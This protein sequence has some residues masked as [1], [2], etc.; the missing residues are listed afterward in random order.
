MKK[1]KEYMD[2]VK[3]PDTLHRRLR[4]LKAPKKKPASWTRYGSMAAALALVCGLGGFLAWTGDVNS[5]TSPIPSYP[6]GHQ[7]SA[8]EIT[9]ASQ[10]DIAIV[11]PG[12]VTEPGEKTLGGYD[13]TGGGVTAHYI[14][15]YIEYGD[16]YGAAETVM[17]W[18]IPAGAVKRE[19]TRDEIAALMGGEDAVDTHL[20]WGGYELTGW[21]AWY[22]DGSFWGAYLYGCRGP[23]D[24]FEFAVT[25]GQLPPTCVAYAN[26]V[27]QE[28]RGL[29]V[30]A[31]GY[32]GK[33]GCGRRISFMKDDYG[34]RFDLTATDTEQA[35]LLVSRLVR[36]VADKGLELSAVGAAQADGSYTCS[37]CGRTVQEGAEHVHSNTFIGVGEPCYEDGGASTEPYDPAAS[38]E[39]CGLPLADDPIWRETRAPSPPAQCQSEP[40]T[41][42]VLCSEGSADGRSSNYEWTYTDTARGEGGSVIACGLHP[43]DYRDAPSLTTA[44]ETVRLNF[45]D[46]P[47]RVSVVCWPDSQ[48]GNTSA[49][50]QA[51]QAG[52]G[53][54][55]YDLTLNEGGWVYEISAQWDD[56]GRAAYVFHLTKT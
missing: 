33:G 19:L 53:E 5:R 40:P 41:L 43:L 4:E 42:R 48:W 47:D 22:E 36:R 27:T 51:A 6:I 20:D 46:L 54:H 39:I 37:V 28:I 11:E 23:L 35:E 32:D 26:S 50:S 16:T 49:A 24:H 55:A 3:A 1:Y 7:E 9:D 10:P 30:T 14:L 8:A 15:P 13:V 18:D 52:H 45:L 29:T 44:D 21:A 34:Y 56:L 38:G 2:S 12:D 17:D 31:D 25:A